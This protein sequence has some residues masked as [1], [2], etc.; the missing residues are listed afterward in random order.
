MLNQL[1][2]ENMQLV[3]RLGPDGRPHPGRRGPDRP[4]R[5]QP[6]RQRPRRDAGRRNGDDRDRPTS[7]SRS[8]T[9]SST[10]TVTPGRT[11]LLAVSDTGHGDGPR[12]P[13][14]HL[15]ALLHD[16]G[17]RQGDR[18]RPGHDYGIVHQAGGHIWL[19]SEPGQGSAFKLY[20]P[21]RRCGPSSE[22]QA[23]M[24]ATPPVGSG[25][26]PRRGGRAMRSAT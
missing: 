14:A 4:D 19:Y 15:R 24:P 20:F 3:L 17:C 6:R 25:T 8:R 21:S 11:S 1:I 13:R 12:D 9:S 5:G 2:G 18:P 22:E 7:C 10:S 26:R 16:Q 23:P